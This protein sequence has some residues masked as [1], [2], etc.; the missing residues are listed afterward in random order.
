MGFPDIVELL[1]DRQAEL[2]RQ[3]LLGR[4]PLMLAS[5]HGHA[6]C[7]RVLLVNNAKIG[8]PDGPPKNAAWTIGGT[9]P[10]ETYF[11]SLNRRPDVKVYIKDAK[12]ERAGGGMFAQL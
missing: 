2:E 7:V 3:N 9:R 12:R 1:L 8:P 11:A 4:T 10:S 6:E 5:E